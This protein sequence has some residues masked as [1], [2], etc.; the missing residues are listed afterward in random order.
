M[1]LSPFILHANGAQ[2]P[3][4]TIQTLFDWRDR[5]VEQKVGIQFSETD[6]AHRPIT[7]YTFDNLD[8]VVQRDRYDGDGVSLDTIGF[9][10][11]V[12]NA[13]CASLLRAR[14]TSSI[15]DQGRVYR[16]Q[17]YSVDQSNGTV[18]DSMATDTFYDHRGNAVAVF[19]SGSATS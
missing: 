1:Y 4:T 16:S 12:P 2:Q 13:P 9:T 7:Y 10:N 19:S 5:A 6:S 17:T 14:S 11:G 3:S 18:G 15:D 8:E